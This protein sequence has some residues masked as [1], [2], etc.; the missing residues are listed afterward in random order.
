MLSL[1][2]LT[3]SLCV[4]LTL[5]LSAS[6]YFNIK[7]ALLIIKMQEAIEES[8]DILDK[9]YEKIDAILKTPVFFDSIE[10]RQVITE[11]RSSRDSILYLA[12]IL[13]AVTQD[14]NY[15]EQP[16]KEINER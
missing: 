3:S 8:L 12:N 16:E 7:H 6:I 14:E 11:I 13:A 5:I 4:F 15:D 2:V 10:I 9:K 1:S